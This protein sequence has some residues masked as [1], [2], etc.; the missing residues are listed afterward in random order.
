MKR[1]MQLT[2]SMLSVILLAALAGG[3]WGSRVQ[4]TSASES[5]DQL[6]RTYAQ[7]LSLAEENYA[8][9]VDLEKTV[10]DSIRGMVRTL[11]PHSNFFDPETYSQFREE[12]QGN[13]YGLGITVAIR[14]SKPTVISPIPGTPAYR[15]GIRPGDVIVKIGGKPTDGLPLQEIIDQ[16]RGPKGTTVNISV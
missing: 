4:A 1:T 10:Y 9:A 13:Y 11:D 2:A 6:L 5:L 14:N 8:D 16:L 12:Q 15:Q 3:V 7:A